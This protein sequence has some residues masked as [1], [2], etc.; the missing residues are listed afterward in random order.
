MEHY[1][2]LM[3]KDNK[4]NLKKILNLN[5]KINKITLYNNFLNNN[6]V[7]IKTNKGKIYKIILSY[8]GNYLVT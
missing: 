2:I 5:Y 1:T 4:I 8:F 7:D 6:Y 3:Q